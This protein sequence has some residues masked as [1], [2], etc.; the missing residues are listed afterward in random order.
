MGLGDADI[1]SL[2]NWAKTGLVDAILLLLDILYLAPSV[3]DGQIISRLHRIYKT[4][5]RIY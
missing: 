2:F 4:P 5:F 3:R 1:H